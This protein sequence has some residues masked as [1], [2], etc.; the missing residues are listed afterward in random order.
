MN[1]T[2][3]ICVFGCERMLA[4]I[5]LKWKFYCVF[6]FLNHFTLFY[7]RRRVQIQLEKAHKTKTK[8]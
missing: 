2:A 6:S 5:R 7:A 3:P 4:C 8:E 1:A